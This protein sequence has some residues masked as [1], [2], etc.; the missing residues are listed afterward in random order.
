MNILPAAIMAEN[1]EEMER[2]MCQ[3]LGKDYDRTTAQQIHL[4]QLHPKI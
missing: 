4:Q 1:P 3:M 2:G